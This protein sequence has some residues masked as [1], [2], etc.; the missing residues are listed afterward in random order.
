MPDTTPV[1]CWHTDGPMICVLPGGHDPTTHWM[2]LMPEDPDG[3][4]FTAKAHRLG[5][6]YRGAFDYWRK[7]ERYIL[8]ARVGI[9]FDLS[10]WIPEGIG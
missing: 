4:V 10:A 9:P 5:L 6:S 7:R 2:E 1:Y 8:T 3:A